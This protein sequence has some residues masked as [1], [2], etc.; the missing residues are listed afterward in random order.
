NP[1]S[2]AVDSAGNVY[3]ADTQNNRIRAIKGPIP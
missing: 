1:N 3:I 2:V